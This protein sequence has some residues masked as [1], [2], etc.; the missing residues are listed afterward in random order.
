MKDTVQQIPFLRL[1]IALALGIILGSLFYIPFLVLHTA[2]VLILL[3]LFLINRFYRYHFTNLFG[4]FIN[5]LFILFG[6]IVFQNQNKKPAFH[7]EGIYLGT[8]LERPQEKQNSYKSVLRI[9]S[10]MTKNDSIHR[11]T[12]KIIVYFQKTDS[13]HPL[14]PGEQIAFQAA[15]QQIENYGNPYEFDYK[16]YLSRR[17]IYRQVYLSSDN[18][19]KSNLPSKFSLYLYAEQTRDKLL[20]LYHKQNLGAKET[21]IL[22]ALTLGYKRELDQDTKQIFSR[23]GAM[24]ILAVSG[25]HVG[26]IYWVIVLLFS[27]LRKR[28]S[29]KF[30]FVLFTV[31]ILWS[32]A[33]ITGLSP[34]VV[35]ASIMFSLFVI[36][37]NISRKTNTYN[38]L[39]VSALLILLS[40]PNNLF[41]VGFQLS[42]SAVFGIVFL[43]PRIAGL[44]PIRNKVIQFFWSLLTVSIAA[45]IAT[46]P[47]T[48]FY[49]NQFP[50][51]FWIT[52]L[53]IIPSVMVLIPLGMALLLFSGIPCI[54]STLSAATGFLIKLSYS[55]LSGIEQLPFSAIEISIRPVELIFMAGLFVAFFLIIDSFKARNIKLFLT[56]AFLFS[57]ICL[58]NN[59]IQLKSSKLIVY[60]TSKNFALHLI[61][62]KKSVVILEDKNANQDRIFDLVQQTKRKLRIEPSSFYGA[63]DTITNDFLCAQNGVLDFNN[64]IILFNPNFLIPAGITSLHYVMNPKNL[65]ELKK[66][67]SEE[68]IF[69]TNKSYLSNSKSDSIR[70]HNTLKQGAF[71]ENW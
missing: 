40:N 27:F 33:F 24:H 52:N 64:Q 8:V 47:L 57:S 54:A 56:F 53:F 18:W 17:N 70:L 9:S 51:Y 37:D 58:I 19:Q 48:S 38:S 4:I 26:I 41:E 69:I 12:E 43:Q 63:N 39:A 66:Y 22:S 67:N 35:R 60:N 15:P 23:A 36:G 61:S 30:L 11:T 21:E 2:V 14:Q 13:V 49:F 42:Y 68:T 29:G 62:G 50:I 6:S 3:S 20:K 31:S 59:L 46:F 44:I 32:Y 55:F 5:L 71:T 10:V 65:K 34:S 7:E 25:L 1:S 45:Q 28:R 16:K